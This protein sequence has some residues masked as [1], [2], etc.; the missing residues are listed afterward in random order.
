MAKISLA[1]LQKSGQPL[2][3]TAF[4]FIHFHVYQ[5]IIG[6]QDLEVLGGKFF[7]Q[8]NFT[9]LANFSLHPLSSQIELT[10]KYDGNYL[11]ESSWS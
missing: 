6:V 11:G 9:L 2:F 3:D 4:N 1:E 8:T 7:N 5:G 10:L